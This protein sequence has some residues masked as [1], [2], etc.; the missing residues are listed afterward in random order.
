M[1]QV[2]RRTQRAFWAKEIARTEGLLGV[3]EEGQEGGGAGME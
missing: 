2:I 3:F 1:K